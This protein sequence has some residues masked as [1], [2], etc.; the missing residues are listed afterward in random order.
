ML[1]HEVSQLKSENE[2]LRKDLDQRNKLNESELVNK[3]L[4]IL[5]SMIDKCDEKIVRSAKEE[6]ADIERMLG[7]QMEKHNS[8]DVQLEDH[9]M[10]DLKS[11][12]L[13][14][15]KTLV[16][17]FNHKSKSTNTDKESEQGDNEDITERNNKI[18][19]RLDKNSENSTKYHTKAPKTTQN[20]LIT[21]RSCE[22]LEAYDID[23]SKSMN[24][25]FSVCSTESLL[26][27]AAARDNRLNLNDGLTTD[28][29][30]QHFRL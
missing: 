5:H 1:F 3:M 20:N 23:Q 9:E 12:K 6:I 11:K 19:K 8:S 16:D 4:S 29:F 22:S 18:S 15:T 27:M 17:C 2:Q 30:S 10:C 24:D 26:D 14:N 28:Y 21:K 7:I 13:K 25:N